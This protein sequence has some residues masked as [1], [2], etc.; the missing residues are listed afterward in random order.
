MIVILVLG[1]AEIFRRA[2]FTPSRGVVFFLIAVRSTVNECL[3]FS[4][5]LYYCIVSRFRY[6]FFF[7]YL[8]KFISGYFFS[9][10]ICLFIFISSHVLD[11]RSIQLHWRYGRCLC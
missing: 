3:V 2:I 4:E 1:E 7:W 10:S 6:S 5:S 9:F 8:F 11:S